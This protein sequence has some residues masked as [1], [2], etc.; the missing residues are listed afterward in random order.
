MLTVTIT[1][2]NWLKSVS[3]CVTVIIRVRKR[4]IVNGRVCPSECQKLA[5]FMLDINFFASLIII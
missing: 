1:I 5:N 3:L 2:P 4:S